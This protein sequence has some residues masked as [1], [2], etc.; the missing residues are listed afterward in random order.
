M[1][2][3]TY[4][5][6]NGE[7]NSDQYYEDISKFTDLLLIHAEKQIELIAESFQL[8]L[9][10]TKGEILRSKSEYIFELLTLGTL[11]R[12]YEKRAVSLPIVFQK[13]LITLAALRQKYTW[14]K[15]FVDPI[16]GVLISL[17][18]TKNTE[19]IFSK[20][21]FGV[22]KIEKLL[23][24]LAASGDYKQEVK[25][26]KSW[27][28]YISILPVDKG[29]KYIFAAMDFA[30]WFEK[31]SKKH[32]GLY[33]KNVE[34]FLEYEHYKYKWRED[35]IFCGRQQ[36]EYHLN[37]VGAVI[38]NRAWRDEFLSTERKAG[39]VPACMRAKSGFHCKWEFNG[40]DY[41]CKSCTE[42]CRV[43]KLTKLGKKEGFG[44]FM[45]PHSTDFTK[46]LSKRSGNKGV[47]IIG[48]TCTLNLMT[49]GWEAKSLDI[50]INCVLLDYCGCKNHWDDKGFPTS[51][52]INELRRILDLKSETDNKINIKE[53]FSENLYN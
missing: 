45:I 33:T 43:N 26:L 48:V 5:L 46:W 32:L 19:T 38:I 20:S 40:I 52:N 16:R 51:M 7:K 6:N 9:V 42:N 14:L 24:W 25:R 36:V 13:I 1:K 50:P 4:S 11:I 15:S 41:S 8:Y 21:K 49:G 18:L 22:E 47:G 29:L 30:K 10:K 34:K 44:V 17:F 12:T 37:M 28:E 39:L 31:E 35:M 53:I 2:T 3:I 27:K 23:D